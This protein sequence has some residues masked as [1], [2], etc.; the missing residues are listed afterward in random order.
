MKEIDDL[1]FQKHRIAF[2][3]KWIDRFEMIVKCLKSKT[4][5]KEGDY[6]NSPQNYFLP[7]KIEIFL[8]LLEDQI[9]VFY[10]Q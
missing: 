5:F 7:I 2:F 10:K 8:D 9:S 3:P 1:R 6:K 4:K